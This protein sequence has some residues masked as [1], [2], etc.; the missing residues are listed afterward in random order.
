MKFDNDRPDR[1]I[2]LSVLDVSLYRQVSENVP[3][4]EL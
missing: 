2:Y 4:V 1:N 3:V